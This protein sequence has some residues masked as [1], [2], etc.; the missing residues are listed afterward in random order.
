MQLNNENQILEKNILLIA[1]VYNSFDIA[2]N[3][4]NSI[5]K[6]KNDNVHVVIIDNSIE[7]ATDIFLNKLKNF[8][9]SLTYIKSDKNVGYFGGAQIGLENYLKKYNSPHW[10]IVSN[11]DLEINDYW[12]FENLLKYNNFK[13]IAVIAPSI[14]SKTFG[15]DS[16]PQYIKRLSYFKINLQKFLT[17][18]SKIH[19]L[20]I[21]L[22]YIKKIIKRFKRKKTI[23]PTQKYIYSAHGSFIIFSKNY[24]EKGGTLNHISFLFGEEIFVAETVKKLNLETLFCPELIINDYEHV[25]TGFFHSNKLTKVKHDSIKK[26]IEYYYK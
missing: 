23:K 6:V 26:I 15:T 8:T 9:F 16:N 22:S 2:L 14:I 7:N 4:F 3:F 10:V 18:N 21:S 12:F 1:I 19:N 25:S 24:F 11:V 17:L 20:Y 13:N 5:D